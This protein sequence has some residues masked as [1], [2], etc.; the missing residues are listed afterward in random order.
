MWIRTNGHAQRAE[1][2]LAKV[3]SFGKGP[4]DHSSS[5]LDRIDNPLIG[6]HPPVSH[7]RVQLGSAESLKQEECANAECEPPWDPVPFLPREDAMFQPTP[8]VPSRL[9]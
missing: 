6:F 7:V 2:G 5:G 1:G 4:E 3:S 9:D 8:F